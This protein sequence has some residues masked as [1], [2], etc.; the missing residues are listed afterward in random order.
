MEQAADQVERSEP[1]SS[2]GLRTWR[3]E[4][5]GEARQTVRRAQNGLQRLMRQNPLLVGAAAMLVGAAVGAAL[6][7][8][9]KE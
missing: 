4:A 6:P 9:E 7:E 1:A 5:T 8:T 2:E 3:R